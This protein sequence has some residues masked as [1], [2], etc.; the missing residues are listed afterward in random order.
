M[1]ATGP[2]TVPLRIFISHLPG[3]SRKAIV[4]SKDEGVIR[5]SIGPL[6]V[7]YTVTALSAANRLT[8]TDLVL[9]V[10]IFTVPAV[11][12]RYQS[13]SRRRRTSA[14]VLH[15]GR[16]APCA[17]K[18]I[19]IRWLLRRPLR[20]GTHSGRVCGLSEGRLHYFSSQRPGRETR[21]R[22]RESR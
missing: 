3:R 8:C 20:L 12:R 4:K 11:V 10:T 6:L 21:S 5:T 22:Q 14:D 18:G 9:R 2:R 15:V 7:H 17:P 19:A 1:W 16:L 13:S